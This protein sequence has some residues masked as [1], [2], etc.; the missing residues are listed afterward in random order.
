MEDNTKLEDQECNNLLTECA[1]LRSH[2]TPDAFNV[3]SV[4]SQFD[5]GRTGASGYMASRAL[6]DRVIVLVGRMQ[7]LMR[8]LG[9]RSPTGA[10]VSV[11][12]SIGLGAIVSIGARLLG[13]GGQG[14]RRRVAGCDGTF[15]VGVSESIF[16]LNVP[17]GAEVEEEDQHDRRHGNGRRP[18]VLGPAASHADAGRRAD[19]I[20]GGVEEVNE[21][22]RDDDAGTEVAGEQVDIAR[23]SET[24]YAGGEDREEGQEGRR[25]EENEDGRDTGADA[26]IELVAAPIHVADDV[27]GVGRIEIDAVGIEGAIGSGIVNVGHCRGELLVI[28][29]FC[30]A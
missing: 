3:D 27:S 13:V 29:E 7:E 22:R 28:G 21:G 4:W 6:E 14:R 1:L 25:D 26:A 17:F 9:L 10:W 8:A 18:R 15:D 23:Y 5:C 16:L 24:R 2:L 11:L 20:V 30:R 12:D 19:L